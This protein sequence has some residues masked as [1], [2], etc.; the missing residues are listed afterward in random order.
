MEPPEV[1]LLETAAMAGLTDELSRVARVPDPGATI[2]SGN[3][4]NL[5]RRH[6]FLNEYT[7]EDLEKYSLATLL[8]LEATSIKLK[9]LENNKAAEVKLSNNRDALEDTSYRVEE[10]VDNRWSN[11]HDCRFLPGWGCTSQKMWSR[12]REV[13]KNNA[14]PA[15]AT[16]DMAS[17]GLAGHVTS[18]GWVALHNPG[19]SNLA[20]RMFSINNCGRRV[21]GKN[22]D[23]EDNLLADIV[24]L[25]ELKLAM[26]VLKEAI[27]FVRPWDKSVAALDGFLHQTNYC[28]S[29]T[30]GLD[31]RAEL[32]AQFID[33]ILKENSN[34]WKGREQFL[35]ITELKG[36]WE[37][38]FGSRPQGQLAKAKQGQKQQGQKS[39]NNSSGGGGGQQQ[40]QQNQV[41]SIMVGKYRVPQ[42]FFNEDICVMYNV[43]KCVKSPNNCTTKA[44]KK[45]RHVCNW[46][47]YGNPNLPA[48]GLQHAAVFYH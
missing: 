33:Y 4:D 26:R 30:D 47:P 41:P 9:N 25:G 46:R 28:A 48:C 38:F 23:N 45:L 21:A 39:Y 34:R 2:L 19:S 24:E 32:M 1:M 8:K 10:G 6:A 22:D 44:G 3:L 36:T 27:S 13:L 14:H 15:I 31:K 16:Y 43:G 42:A 37:S 17:V 7:S 11:L 20:I 18:Q 29:D 35:G 5:R 12:G 40:Q